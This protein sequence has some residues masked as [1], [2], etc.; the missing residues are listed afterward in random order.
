M[1]WNDRTISQKA[2]EDKSMRASRP[3]NHIALRDG[4][5]LCR[6][7]DSDHARVGASAS[8]TGHSQTTGPSSHI[9]RWWRLDDRHND[10]LP[11]RPIEHF[12]DGTRS[13]GS[14][15]ILVHRTLAY[16]G[17]IA[18]VHDGSG[19]ATKARA[20]SHSASSVNS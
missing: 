5:G 17:H 3:L 16:R 1:E 13:A 12:P 7:I 9:P 19:R 6:Y 11:L 2:P 4:Q 8:A 10:E 14:P 20:H 15:E 18:T